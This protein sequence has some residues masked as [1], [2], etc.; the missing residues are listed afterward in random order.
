MKPL[1]RKDEDNWIYVDD[2]NQYSE[3]EAICFSF[4][5]DYV[6]RG[7]T[8]GE[9]KGRTHRKNYQVVVD[10]MEGDFAACCIICPKLIF[11]GPRVLSQ[12]SA[13]RDVYTPGMNYTR[14]QYG[15][16]SVKIKCSDFYW[17]LLQILIKK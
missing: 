14:N 11:F 9:I 15:S 1:L 7:H 13:E 4:K 10:A 8:S 17:N 12:H 6:P 16:E 5:S 3:E 2:Q